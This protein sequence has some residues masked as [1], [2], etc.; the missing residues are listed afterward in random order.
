MTIDALNTLVPSLAEAEFE[1]CCGSR[2]WARMMAA[3]RPFAN[4]AVLEAVAQRLWWSLS[5]ADWLEAFAAHPRIGERAHSQWSAE[6][7]AGASGATEE[8]RSRLAQRNRDYEER[9]GY[10]FVVCATGKSAEEMLATLEGRLR[11]QPDDE[12]QVA[13]DE[14]RKITTLR[15]QKL[16]AG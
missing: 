1:R 4:R 7:Q 2:R 10:T 6:E 9:F 5:A 15:L 11:N 12:L 8:I 14:Q 13:A 3:E 16:V